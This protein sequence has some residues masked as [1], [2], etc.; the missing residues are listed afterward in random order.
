MLAPKERLMTRIQPIG[1]AVLL[2]IASSA[3]AQSVPQKIQNQ[4]RLY[5]S[6]GNPVSGT[7]TLVFAIYAAPSG[8]TPLWSSSLSVTVTDG[9]YGAT[10]DGSGSNAFPV[11][12]WSGAEVYLGITVDQDAE[13]T[14][15]QAIDSVPYAIDAIPTGAMM[16]FAGSAAPLGWLLC[17]GSA[18]SR[19]TYPALFGVLGTTYGAGDGTTT[20]NVPDL[21]GRVAVA[22]DPGSANTTGITAVGQVGGEQF[23]T[24]TVA[25][26]PVHNHPVTDPGHNHAVTDPGHAHGVTDPGHGHMVNDPGHSHATL[27]N[28]VASG[29]ASGAL[30]GLAAGGNFGRTGQAN[31]DLLASTGITIQPSGTG[32]SVNN[33]TTG[34][35]L[36][37]AQTGVSV[38]N[39]G[40]G[41]AHNIMQPYLVTQKIIKY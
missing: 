27:Y 31:G 19:T 10:L 13:M 4:G 39:A 32:I 15:R 38:G 35:S 2:L 34:I 23:H 8:G 9:F 22:A 26:L 41:T 29:D 16:D 5:N 17:D 28:Y 40:G 3:L 33:A 1:A 14:P 7:H 18:V 36:Q 12:L 24:L 21:R 6:A 30:A 11:G 20:F 37:P 25:E